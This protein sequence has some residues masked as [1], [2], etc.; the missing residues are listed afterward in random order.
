VIGRSP[1]RPIFGLDNLHWM[2]TNR[3]RRT[4][5]TQSLDQLTVGRRKSDDVSVAGAAVEIGDPE[6]ADSR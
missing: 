2:R 1:Q 3:S 6:P 5:G 4:E